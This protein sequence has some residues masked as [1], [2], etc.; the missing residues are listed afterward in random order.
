[1]GRT[2]FSIAHR[3]VRKHKKSGQFH[4]RREPDR[5]SRVVAEDEEG[6]AEGPHFGQRES[7]HNRSHRVFAN[8]EMQVLTTRA[9]SL[10]ISRAG[11]RQGGLV[12][13]PEVRRAAEEP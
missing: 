10:E 9:I 7:V 8:S 13:W 3:L 5:W 12:R 11:K 1:M 2:V 6:R 4:E